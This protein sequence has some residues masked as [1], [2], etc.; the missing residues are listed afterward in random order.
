MRAGRARVT[1]KC[2]R[3][4]LDQ[5]GRA[6]N[7][8]GRSKIRYMYL[9]FVRGY[10]QA[11]HKIVRIEYDVGNHELGIRHWK[12]SANAGYQDSLNRLRDIFN[13][14]GK[15]PGKEFV[16]KEELDT[17][18]RKY[19]DVQKEVKSEEREKYLTEE[20]SAVL[21]IDM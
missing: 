8:R 13:A 19:H 2:W 9:P 4:L 18:Y 5:D 6:Q 11:H 16:G 12:I 1:W 7:A 17:L 15:L 10:I 14:D 3:G 20:E 21:G